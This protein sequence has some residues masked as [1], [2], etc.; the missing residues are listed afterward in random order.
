M[1]VELGYWFVC[2]AL[3]FLIVAMW[4]RRVRLSFAVATLGWGLLIMVVLTAIFDNLMIA[5]GLFD[6]GEK[7]LLGVRIGR[8]PL[9]DFLYPLSSILL[10]PALWWIF[11]S[12]KSEKTNK[13]RGIK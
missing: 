5:A 13:I 10:M 1:F 11:S 6:Y 4:V 8:A 2:I 12:P 3:V 7:T 9:E